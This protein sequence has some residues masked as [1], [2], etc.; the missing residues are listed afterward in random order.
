MVKSTCFDSPVS[1]R[2]ALAI[3]CGGV[4]A[5]GGSGLRPINTHSAPSLASPVEQHTEPEESSEASSTGFAGLM[6]S[7][8][9][10]DQLREMH[11]GSANRNPHSV[12]KVI[13]ALERSSEQGVGL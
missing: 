13:R 4:A 7:L 5:F 12:P 3:A 8:Q 6:A 2:R 1:R 9:G 11:G 10:V